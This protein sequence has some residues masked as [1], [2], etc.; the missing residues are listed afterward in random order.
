[1]KIKI[2]IN[3]D[4]AAFEDD[5]KEGVAYVLSELLVNLLHEEASVDKI[6]LRDINGNTVGRVEVVNE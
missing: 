4:G 3:M 2:Q 1:M 5:W 6:N